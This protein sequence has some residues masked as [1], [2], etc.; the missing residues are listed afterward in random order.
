MI[1]RYRTSHNCDLACQVEGLHD[2]LVWGLC[3][4]HFRICC[5]TR[6]IGTN[7]IKT[8]TEKGEVGSEPFPPQSPHRV[9][10]DVISNRCDFLMQLKVIRQLL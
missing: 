2:M 10:S 8:S 3:E 6:G 1:G 7:S 5:W 4:D 9:I